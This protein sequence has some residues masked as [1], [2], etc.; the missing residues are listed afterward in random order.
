MATATESLIVELDAKID[1]YM[2][3]MGK[4]DGQNKKTGKS[5]VQV[6]KSAFDMSKKVA[7]AALAV[8]AA[9]TA[10]VVSTANQRKEFEILSK[11]AKLTVK[12]FKAIT[13]ATN[14]AGVNAEQFADISKDI[15]DRL[16]E[17]AAA[18][19]GTFQDYADVVGLSKTQ[20]QELAIEWQNLSG[21]QVLGR[22]VQGM[23]EAGASG[24]EMTFVM[25][26]MGN[27]ASRLTDLF[28]D[29]GKELEKQ[30]DRFNKL[31]EGMEITAAQGEALKEVAGNY[32]TMTTQLG[33][34]TDKISATLAPVISD[35]FNDVI[36]IVPQATQAVINFINTLLDAKDINSIEDIN[37]QLL[38]VDETLQK[39]KK[40]Y[41]L[42]NESKDLQVF[43]NSKLLGGSDILNQQAAQHADALERQAELKERLVFLQEE[44]TRLSDAK[45]LK[46]GEIGGESVKLPNG[47]T[48]EEMQDAMALE[49]E[50]IDELHF[51]IV[52]KE[53]KLQEKLIR[54]R[55][56]AAKKEAKAVKDAKDDDK[57]FQ[58]SKINNA[59]AWSNIAHQLNDAYFEDNKA[60]SAG[61]IV[62]DTA[63]GMMHQFTSG[64]PYTAW[65]RAA[66]VAVSGAIALD[67]A[68]SAQKG[69]GSISASS[70]GGA[71]ASD[72]RQPE[73]ETSRLE[74]TESS[75]E[76]SQVSIMMDGEEF[77]TAIMGRMEEHQR[78][79]R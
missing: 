76:G 1:K 50:M 33:A 23:E 72:Q 39:T 29:N 24:N 22:M 38:S 55:E 73:Q 77:M 35:F 62:A 8:S 69:G 21:D 40:S 42:I 78:R 30:K 59:Q 36:S 32:K 65:A 63:L 52:E 47:L 74:V 17:F 37:T 54:A 49:L 68:T 58:I 25:E 51:E 19:T 44:E 79:G 56:R 28:K 53:E 10:M 15:A 45:I 4:A 60:V 43:A 67:Q 13:F 27:D 5:M 16:G 20:A 66:A 41:D 3:S 26:S 6:G 71:N 11:Q 14:Q 31:T 18:G 9:I 57:K 64:D 75:N 12:E 48:P 34:A 7:T 2:K 70:G 61:L 46:G